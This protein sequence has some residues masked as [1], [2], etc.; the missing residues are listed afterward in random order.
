[1]KRT[2]TLLA[3][4]LVASACTSS[5]EPGGTLSTQPPPTPPEGLFPA[6]SSTLERTPECS[7]YGDLCDRMI[8]ELDQWRAAIPRAAYSGTRRLTLS[9]DG[10]FI[11][12]TTYVEPKDDPGIVRRRIDALLQT[13]GWALDASEPRSMWRGREE[14]AGWLLTFDVAAQGDGSKIDVALYAPKQ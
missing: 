4:A 1:M 12:T 11:L 5:L 14:I 2:I 7:R 9:G 13:R 6:V 3:L 8:D 10:R